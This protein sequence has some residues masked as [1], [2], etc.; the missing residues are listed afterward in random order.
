[1]LLISGEFRKALTA[2]AEI[3]VIGIRRTAK[4]TAAEIAGEHRGEFVRMAHRQRP[5]QQSINDAEDHAIRPDPERE[6]EHGH[7][8]E[9]GVLQQLTKGEFQVVHKLS[10]LFLC[11]RCA[12][13]MGA[14]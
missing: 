6:R 13:K 2:R 1:M 12:I 7:G 11:S 9:A 4:S 5:Q 8:G 3:H 10:P 14:G